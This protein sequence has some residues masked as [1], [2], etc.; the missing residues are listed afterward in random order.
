MKNA[1]AIY[2]VLLNLYPRRYQNTF[3]AQMMQTFLDNYQDVET[4]E[5]RT[6]MGFWFSTISDE[7]QNI[8]RQHFEYLAEENAFLQ[9]TATKLL[10]TAVF[11]I[12]WCVL[13]YA[14]LV[15]V[16]LAMPHPHVN[17][18]GALIALSALLLLSGVL[19]LA[20]SYLSASALVSVLVKRNTRTT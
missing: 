10:A 20:A 19:G 11:F 7:A 18:I 4:W 9:V 8:L 12:P 14:A 13:F 15:H 6:S 2:K 1:K 5:K 3:G 17:G 16:M